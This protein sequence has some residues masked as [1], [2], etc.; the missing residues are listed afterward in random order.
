M[1]FPVAFSVPSEI[2]HSLHVLDFYHASLEFPS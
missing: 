2:Q 1:V